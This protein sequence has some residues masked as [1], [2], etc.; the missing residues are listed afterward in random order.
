MLIMNYNDSMA[1]AFTLLSVVVTATNLPIYIGCALAV[2]VLWRRRQIP[3]P[4][5]REW[6]WI[7]AAALAA[8]YCVWASFGIGRKPLVQALSV[9]VPGI[10]VYA[11]YW[12]ISGRREVAPA[13]A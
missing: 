8:I 9:C 13:R 2:L 12:W 11:V 7:A 5:A 10:V 4:G 1:G 3:R 6:R